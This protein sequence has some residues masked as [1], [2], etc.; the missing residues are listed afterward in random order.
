MI[1]LN[2]KKYIG[3]S[4]IILLIILSLLSVDLKI[5]EIFELQNL[6]NILNFLNEF[7]NPNLSIIF[8]KKLLFSLFETLLISFIST[9]CAF[10]LTFFILI[11]CYECSNKFLIAIKLIL[12]FLRSIPELIWAL[13]LVILLGLG[14]ITGIFALFIHTTGVLGKLFLDTVENTS[15]TENFVFR[16]SGANKIKI[17]FSQT[18]YKIFPNLLNFTF[19]R[20]ENNIRAA[21]ILG[22]IGA[23]GVGQLL[24]YHMSLFNYNEVSTIT[25]SIILIIFLVD[26]LSAFI[27]SKLIF[28]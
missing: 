4:I 18:F 19:Y 22:F 2:L 24:Y 14:P 7:L 27:R 8:L 28:N 20:W 12:S 5:Y 9:F 10:L 23:G 3:F 16:I 11:I 6:L 1:E 15:T 21:S 26:S 13:I 25:I 17:F